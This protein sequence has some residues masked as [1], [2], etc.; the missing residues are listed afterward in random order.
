MKASGQGPLLSPEV[1]VDVVNEARR[2]P[3]VHNI[4]PARFRHVAEGVIELHANPGSNLPVADPTGQDVRIS[5]GASCEGLGIALST[6]GFR[7]EAVELRRP[8]S[9]LVAT[10]VFGAGGVP[11]RLAPHVSH[12]ATWRG[13]FEPASQT[14]LDALSECARNQ[15]AVLVRDHRSLAMVARLMGPSGPSF[16]VEDR[17]WR[18]TWTWLRLSPAHPMWNRDGLNGEA[19]H[20]SALGRAGARLFMSP[21]VFGTLRTLGLAQ[22]LVSEEPQVK[23]A[24]ALLVLVAPD[25]EDPFEAGRRFYRIWLEVT[26]QGLALCPMSVLADAPETQAALRSLWKVPSGRRI[27]NVLRIGRA[28]AQNA[29]AL[30]ARIPAE[31]LVLR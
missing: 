30:T 24:S 1:W 12:R 16:T 18:E 31:E 15:S 4:Q 22:A 26:A 8:A 25:T 6:R 17:Y 19:L 27:V 10:I 21:T 23:S 14:A 13:R 5:L 11:D 20:L 2:A 29:G 9:S 28:P 7:V 3:S